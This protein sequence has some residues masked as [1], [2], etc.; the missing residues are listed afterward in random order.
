MPTSTS[1]LV[2]SRRALL[3]AFA[4]VVAGCPPARAERPYPPPAP[5]DLLHPLEARAARIKSLRS[6]AKVDYLAEK[7]DRIKVSMT[8]IAAAPD[9]LRMDAESPLGGSVASLASDGKQFQLL[10][11]RGN[12]F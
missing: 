3:A 4:F 11:V 12:R 2:R 7:G 8:L 1:P 5:T 10:D 6:D 9:E